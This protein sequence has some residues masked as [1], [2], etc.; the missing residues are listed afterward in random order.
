MKTILRHRML[1]YYGSL[2]TKQQSRASNSL[3]EQLELY[4]RLQSAKHVGGYRAFR[5][6]L[7]LDPLIES[8]QSCY[9]W[10]FPYIHSNQSLTYHKP[11]D[12]SAWVKRH[13]DIFEPDPEHSTTIELDKLDILIMPAIAIDHE[14]YRLGWGLGHYDRTLNIKNRPFTLGVIYDF[15][16]LSQLPR[17]PWDMTVD[18]VI[19]IPCN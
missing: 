13:Y 9:E 1:N 16:Y 14:R 8:T 6:E 3:K 10:Y 4:P 5:Q 2:S 19:V 7:S 17:D 15:Q 12:D 11:N 18:D